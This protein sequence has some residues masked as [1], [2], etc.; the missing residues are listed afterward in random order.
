M[1]DAVRVGVNDRGLFR[2]RSAGR[3]P[4]SRDRQNTA[5]G[6]CGAASD[7]MPYD[8]VPP[9]NRKRKKGLK[10]LPVHFF[11]KAL[12]WSYPTESPCRL[13]GEKFRMD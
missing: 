4:S 9:L 11:L 13:G 2:S 1:P 10:A 6:V 8:G 7:D 12:S 5:A 3:A